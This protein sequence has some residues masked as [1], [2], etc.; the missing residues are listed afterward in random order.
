MSVFRNTTV[1]SGGLLVAWLGLASG[2]LAQPPA[3][4]DQRRLERSIRTAEGTEDYR[5]RV[6]TSLSLQERTQLDVGGYLSFTNLWTNES[7]INSTRLTQ[8][9]VTLFARASVDSAHSFFGRARFVHRSFS[10]GDSFDGRGDRWVQPFFDRYWYEFDLRKAM[11]VY[12]GVDSDFNFNVRAGRQFVDWGSG[13][14]LS[15][16]LYAVKPT[17][18][19]T[20]QFRLEMLAGLTPDHTVDFD[21]SRFT[22]DEKTR[23]GF[24]GGKL[25]FTTEEGTEIYGFVLRMEDYYNDNRA[26]PPLVLNN[27]NFKYNSTYYGAGVNGSIGTDWIY[28]AEGIWQVGQSWSD[29]L[30]G[31][32]SRE[33]VNAA[34]GKLSL[35]YLFRD[36][37]QTKAELE[38]L[39]AT[40]DSDRGTASSTVGG[41]L[42]GTGDHQ[43]LALGYANTG[44]AFAPSLSNIVSIRGGI[45][46]YPFRSISAM[47]ALQMG[48]DGLVLFKY[49]RNGPIDDLSTTRHFLGGEV[50]VYANW[51]VTSD[52][53]ITARYGIFL[54]SAGI[55]GAKNARHFVLVGITLGF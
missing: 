48:I 42:P 27:V 4:D 8:P 24:F 53:S 13:I 23:R 19:F 45:S 34:A 11:S 50:D 12:Q 22:F 31:P 5:L 33:T 3:P 51:R 52:F 41:N 49:N 20:R 9:E 40:G 29:P 32:Q 44:L 18:E 35:A 37:G 39:F 15:E 14:A 46:T 6:D 28:S 1:C 2:A 26:R 17:I 38:M 10:M 36:E 7:A 25:G 47:E 54:P 43:F 55:A 21:A 30:F 16:T